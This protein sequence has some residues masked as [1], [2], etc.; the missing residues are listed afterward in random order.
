MTKTDLVNYIKARILTNGTKSIT[1]AKHQEALLTVIDELYARAP[2]ADLASTSEILTGEIF[3]GKPVYSKMI[4][5]S[6]SINP[7]S[8][9]TLGG[10]AS[11]IGSNSH[12]GIDPMSYFVSSSVN[13]GIH[14][15]FL[16]GGMHS[17]TPPS[18]TISVGVRYGTHDGGSTPEYY[19][20]IFNGFSG[21]VSGLF[22]VIIKYT[23]P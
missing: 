23:K 8:F 13:N 14:S 1:G 16:I 11:L 6:G 17:N 15:Q 10:V 7:G 3:N 18:N 20:S 5:Y 22:Y 4:S 21:T 9:Y 12:Y 2:Q 19:F